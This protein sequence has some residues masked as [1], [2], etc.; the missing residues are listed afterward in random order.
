MIPMSRLFEDDE[1]F[2]L[3]G[4]C[5]IEKRDLMMRTA[6]R[7]AELRDDLNLTVVF[8]SSFD[9]A[10]RTS[11]DSYRG[12]GLEAGLK[13][14][15]EIGETHDFPL[16]TDIH[17]PRQAEPVAEVVDVLQIPAF[18]CRQTDLVTA[19]GRTGRP[20]NIKKGQFLDP[21]S[22]TSLV[23]KVHRTGN[24]NTMVTERGT[25][26]GYGRWV[27]D[28]R[29]LVKMRAADSAVVYDATHSVQLPGARGD[30]SGGQRQF[31]APQAR[32]AVAVGIDGI[33]METHPNP[34]A[35][36]CDGPNM[37]PLDR[38]EPLL[39]SLRAIHDETGDY[40]DRL[41]IEG[42]P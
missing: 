32:A 1:L 24:H 28:M 40:R 41:L 11:I 7:L 4:P 31:I 20:V 39:R 15:E 2:F 18:L 23:E 38:L 30:A 26:F 33:F 13:L 19:A 17:E 14:L 37:I 3:L 22:M 29:N 6:E 25:F 16:I 36:Q 34:D 5:V 12:P 8:K 35:A 21:G 10:N 42:S 9:K 27:V